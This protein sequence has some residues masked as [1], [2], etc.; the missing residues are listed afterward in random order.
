M[1]DETLEIINNKV[2]E[3]FS[4]GYGTTK[5]EVENEQITIMIHDDVHVWCDNGGTT[6]YGAEKSEIASHGKAVIK[7]EVKHAI[8][9]LLNGIIH[10]SDCGKPM[11]R[12]EVK[13]YK[14]HYFAGAYCQ[15]CWDSKWKAIEARETYN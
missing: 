11:D 6:I 15:T 1:K 4:Q 13:G 12:N 14:R 2:N 9:D 7:F 5:F 8:T 3:A 10:C